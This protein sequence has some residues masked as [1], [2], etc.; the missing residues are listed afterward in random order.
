M[1]TEN[2]YTIDLAI[3]SGGATMSMAWIGPGES[4]VL[5]IAT[6]LLA[7]AIGPMDAAWPR[8]CV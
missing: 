2:G 5:G 7:Q 8:D 6:G 3:A 1:P 4:E